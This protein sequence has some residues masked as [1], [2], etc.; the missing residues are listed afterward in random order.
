MAIVILDIDDSVIATICAINPWNH[1]GIKLIANQ[2]YCFEATGEWYDFYGKIPCNANGFSSSEVG[3]QYLWLVEWLRRSPRQK[4]FA[5]IGSINRSKQ[6]YFK[7][8]TKHTF[9]SPYTGEL[10]CFANDVPGFYK[11]NSGD[12]NLQITRTA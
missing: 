12:I 8:G 2:E 11:N 7:I 9:K 5:L 4:W 6:T 3:R 1:T 10:V